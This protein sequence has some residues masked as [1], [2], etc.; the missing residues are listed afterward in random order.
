M[1]TVNLSYIKTEIFLSH[2]STEF[3]QQPVPN[4]ELNIHER[5]DQY[6]CLNRRKIISAKNNPIKGKKH[7]VVA[8]L[9]FRFAAFT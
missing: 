7:T 6:H 1:S 9:L 2:L 4:C 5:G 3:V 8:A